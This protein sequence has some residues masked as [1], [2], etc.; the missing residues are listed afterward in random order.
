[1]PTWLA[2]IMTTGTLLLDIIGIPF[3]GICIII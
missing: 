2:G 1:M 3:I